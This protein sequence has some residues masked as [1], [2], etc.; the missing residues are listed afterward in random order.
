MPA[1][2]YQQQLLNR[3]W[4]LAVAMLPLLIASLNLGY[5]SHAG[6]TGIDFAQQDAAWVIT[7]VATDSPAARAG[8]SADSQLIAISGLTLQRY[9]LTRDQDEIPDYASLNR[10]WQVQQQLAQQV[11]PGKSVQ[12]SLKPLHSANLVTVTVEVEGMGWAR[13]FQRTGMLTVISLVWAFIGLSVALQRQGD[14]RVTVF[15]ALCLAFSSSFLS[16]V[17]YYYRELAIDHDYFTFLRVLNG[18]LSPLIA[19]T[20]LHFFLVFP[21]RFNWHRGPYLAIA[22]YLIP[23]LMVMIYQPRISYVIFY[24]YAISYLLLGCAALAIK[25]LV[26]NTIKDRIQ[27]RWVF[28]GAT[29]FALGVAVLNV[30]PSILNQPSLINNTGIA[31]LVTLL[32]LSM[33]IAISQHRLLD[34]D[35]LFDNT[36]IYTLTLGLLGA[37]D[38]MVISTI[39]NIS[40]G[41]HN[42]NDPMAF[43]LGL[44]LALIIYT[45]LREKVRYWV[46]RLLKR[47]IYSMQQVSTELGRALIAS[48]DVAHA[49][50]EAAS[51]IKQTLHPRI[52]AS[53]IISQ[54]GPLPLEQQINPPASNEFIQAC[55]AV[56]QT[57]LIETLDPALATSIPSG[58]SGG[59]VV[60]VQNTQRALGFFI[61][62]DKQSGLSYNKN[63][64]Q[65]LQMIAGHLTLAIEGLL[66]REL[67]AEEKR[68]IFGDL[69]DDVGSKLLSLL[70]RSSDPESS[71]L[72]R[73]ALQ[74]LRD[75]VS[76][77]D[78]GIL[79]LQDVLA[80]WRAEAQDRLDAAAIELKWQQQDIAQQQIPLHRWR[81]T[82]RILRELINNIIKHA[83][84]STTSIHIQ[85]KGDI[86][87]LTV[88]DNGMG[89]DPEQWKRGRGIS[90]I[91]HRIAKL[92]G[93]VRWLKAAQGG[94]ETRVEIPLVEMQGSMISN[95]P[96][97]G[98]TPPS[99]EILNRR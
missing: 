33:V 1:H 94:C 38:W 32:P 44:W 3:R 31:A 45:P 46:R 67:A 60:A 52:L 49:F 56:K 20:F 81:H 50:Q 26:T 84:A 30:L 61:L 99:G 80:D 68:Q 10:W 39:S 95:A 69:H 19:A 97:Q 29:L 16:Y 53:Y 91:E 18:F 65:L 51:K 25:Y 98:G 74:D 63:D 7:Q 22:I 79:P 48:S 28:W 54:T 71:E 90:N 41:D 89:C 21:R 78:E 40:L 57:K 34:I 77:P 85:F 59:I 35:T 27:M 55:A 13:A 2:H 82:A 43:M 92:N 37:A 66:A 83:A 86:L 23:L 14:E 11:L 8:I 24:L 93:K 4:L 64:Q 70:Y 73:S 47:D 75:V 62:G 72:A 76:Q 87:K 96:H 88:A 58:L 6:Y 42:F 5:L 36:L 15:F 17:G 9:D 12:L